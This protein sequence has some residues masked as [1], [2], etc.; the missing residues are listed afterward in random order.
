MDIFIAT[1]SIP[2]MTLICLLIFVATLSFWV[3]LNWTAKSI[4]RR[5]FVLKHSQ[6]SKESV[7]GVQRGEL[8]FTLIPVKPP[9]PK[10]K[11]K[12]TLVKEVPNEDKSR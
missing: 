5:Y 3:A 6:F 2:I 12:F 1:I 8:A 7:E 11:T 9:Q 4:V 10:P